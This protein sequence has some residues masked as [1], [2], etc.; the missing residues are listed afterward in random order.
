M[1][2]D[3]DDPESLAGF[4]T[5]KVIID[6]LVT[7][8]LTRKLVTLQDLAYSHIEKDKKSGMY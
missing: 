6:R 7:E 2:I 8:C 5:L 3:Q 1:G 4:Q